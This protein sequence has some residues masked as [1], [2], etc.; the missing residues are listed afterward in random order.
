LSADIRNHAVAHL[1]EGVIAEHDR[2]RFEVRVYALG[3]SDDSP[4]RGRIAAAS[5][6]FDVIETSGDA[7][8]AVKI[9]DDEIDILVDLMGHTKGHRARVLASHP[10]RV[11]ATWLGYPAT[12]GGALVDY[13]ITDAF[14]SPA[15]TESAYAERLVRLPQCFL[16]GGLERPLSEPRP[17]AHYGLPDEAT[18]LCS[19]NQ[20]RKLSPTQF[21]LWTEVLRELPEAVLWLAEAEPEAVANLRMAAESRGVS[22]RRLVFAPRLP[23]AADHMARYLVADIAL[24]TFP[25]GSHSTAVARLRSRAHGSRGA[26]AHCG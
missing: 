24:D 17:R 19:F 21:D 16:P 8:L 10:A 22:A 12:L 20:T 3:P 2:S 11:Q 13:L 15:G 25:Y 26:R 9:A 5:E 14:T 18:V 1:V 7:A 23:S 4:V 6:H